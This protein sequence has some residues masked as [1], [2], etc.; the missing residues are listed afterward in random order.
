[1]KYIK[2]LKIYLLIFTNIMILK[3]LRLYYN[4]KILEN[5]C[6]VRPTSHNNS[7]YAPQLR[8]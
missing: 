2:S 4:Y 5:E 6:K 8:W 3:I 7:V 1:M